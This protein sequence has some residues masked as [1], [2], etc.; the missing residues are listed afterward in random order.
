MSRWTLT[1]EGAHE[2]HAGVRAA[3]VFGP[4]LVDV[5]AQGRILWILREADIAAAAETAGGVQ[6]LM[7]AVV[8][9]LQALVDVDAGSV[10]L[11]RQAVT[12][13]T[14]ADDRAVVRE[15]AGVRTFAIVLANAKSV[16][17]RQER[18]HGART[19]HVTVTIVAEMRTAA[20]LDRTPVLSHAKPL[21][22]RQD[23]IG[24][25]G[26]GHVTVLVV[27]QMGTAAVVLQTLVLVRAHRLVPGQDH[28]GR[29][30]AE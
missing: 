20:V 3:R 5:V 19:R 17:L 28:S 7:G 30:G 21:I 14:L 29:A 11:R 15:D 18:P 27:T 25:T 24:R 4:A 13:G 8:P 12:L 23:H 22:L 2:V 26:A 10:V 1:P 16:V 9:Q 6:A